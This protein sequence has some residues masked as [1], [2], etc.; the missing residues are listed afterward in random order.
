MLGVPNQ[1]KTDIGT[2]YYS[3]AL[4]MFCQQFNVTH[5]TKIFIILKEKVLWNF[6]NYIF[7]KNKKGGYYIPMHII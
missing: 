7:L 6:K 4:E 5:V 3:Q 1:I 2:G